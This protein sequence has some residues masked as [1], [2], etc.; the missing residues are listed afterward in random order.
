[1]AHGACGGAV[2]A[3]LAGHVGEPGSGRAAGIERLEAI[4]ELPV[5]PVLQTHDP[6]ALERAPPL[7]ARGR[8]VAEIEQRK[9]V[10]LRLVS[11]EPP[12]AEAPLQVVDEIGPH[13]HR[14]D[15]G[16]G[17][18]RVV[19]QGRAVADGEDV[20]V[21]LDLQGRSRAHEAAVVER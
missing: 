17:A 21:P 15:A 5:D 6:P 16:A 13:A 8:S 3:L 10:L 20:V 7:G 9:E 4:H 11:T 2:A 1:M 18:P 12:P 19:G 14:V